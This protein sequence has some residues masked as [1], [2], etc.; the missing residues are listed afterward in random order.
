M[1]SH[2]WSIK[3]LILLI[4]SYCCPADLSCAF[5]QLLLTSGRITPRL[6]IFH[7][8]FYRLFKPECFPTQQ[9]LTYFYDGNGSY[10]KIKHDKNR[11]KGLVDRLKWC[12][13][14]KPDLFFAFLSK[15]LTHTELFA[16]LYPLLPILKRAKPSM[17]SLSIVDSLLFY[18]TIKLN[19][20]DFLL[21]SKCARYPFSKQKTWLQ[22]MCLICAT[23]D[24]C[25][26]LQF[27]HKEFDLL[28]ESWLAQRVL[29]YAIRHHRDSI[30][31]FLH[32]SHFVSSKDIARET[33]LC[34]SCGYFDGQLRA[35]R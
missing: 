16:E 20:K 3:D 32:H 35:A 24:D 15:D 8:D 9:L 33:T 19:V 34:P 30:V 25:K 18:F 14:K 2:L 26:T 13:N 27:L 11:K 31:Q 7:L 28:S 4:Q 10:E 22:R 23:G 17:S 21:L 6:K 5:L 12:R 1:D 29:S